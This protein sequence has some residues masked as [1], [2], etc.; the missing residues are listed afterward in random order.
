[1]ENRLQK[2][3]R[4][5]ETHI[6]DRYSSLIVKTLVRVGYP[7]EEIL[8]T[9]DEEECNIIVLGSHGKGFLKQNLFGSVSHGVLQRSR[10]PVFVIPIPA[11][12]TGWDFKE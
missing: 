2:F 8:T 12:T 7:I 6:G 4:G 9:A 10:K 5:M 1:M 3:C 11:D